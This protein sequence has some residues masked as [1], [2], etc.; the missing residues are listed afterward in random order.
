MRI[1]RGCLLTHLQGGV[2]W[3]TGNTCATAITRSGDA[4]I[5]IHTTARHTS[6]RA[7]YMLLQAQPAAQ[8]APRFPYGIKPFFYLTIPFATSYASRYG[9]F[10]R[11]FLCWWGAHMHTRSSR[12]GIWRY[13]AQ[14]Y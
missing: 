12:V 8:D 13:E 5:R 9:P 10:Y 4:I 11:H 2:Y 6:A 7:S 14:D 1:V 3:V